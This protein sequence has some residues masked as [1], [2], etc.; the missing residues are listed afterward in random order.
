MKTFKILIAGLYVLTFLFVSGDINAQEKWG[1]SGKFEAAYTFICPCAGEFLQGTLVFQTNNKGKV[2]HMTI[3]GR[4]LEGITIGGFDDQGYPVPSGTPSG[5]R[6][7]FTRADHVNSDTGT[8]V[9]IIRT[10]RLKDGIVTRNKVYLQDG[11]I[12]GADVNCM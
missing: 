11:V 5:N 2:T 9:W 4:M 6:Y 1:K 7:M 10:V 12:I 3:K 8:E